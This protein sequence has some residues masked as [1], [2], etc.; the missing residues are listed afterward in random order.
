MLDWETLAKDP[1]FS[2]KDWDV[3]IR[4]AGENRVLRWGDL[5]IRHGDKENLVAA[6]KK[7]GKYLGGHHHKR[8]E[9]LRTI[10]IGPL[11]GLG[12]AYLSQSITAWQ[13]QFANLTRFNGVTSVSVKTVLYSERHKVARFSYRDKIYEVPYYN[14]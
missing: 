1:R 11:C 5:V 3:W 2:F 14:L 13:L 4:K 10:F 8:L 7:F 9:F 12:P 6:A